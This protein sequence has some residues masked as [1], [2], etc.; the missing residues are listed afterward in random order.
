MALVPGNVAV[1][2]TGLVSRAPLG[3]TAPTTQAVALAVGFIDLGYVGDNGVAQSVPG[4]G[5]TSTIAAWQNGAVV[6]T[7]RAASKDLPTF[8]FT[9]LETKKESLETYYGTTVTQ[10]ATEGSLVFASTALRTHYSWVFD[11]VDGAELERI[12]VPDG[13]VIDVGDRSYANGDAVAYEVTIEAQLNT[14]LA[15]NFKLWS[16]RSK[17]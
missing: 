13:L 8:K 3:T 10:T 2:I 12:Y 5:D 4:S 6:R 16:T 15:G 9:M 14:A 11:L 7:I 1:G 17:T